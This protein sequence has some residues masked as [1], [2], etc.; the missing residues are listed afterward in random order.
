MSAISFVTSTLLPNE[1]H[2]SMVNYATTLK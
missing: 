2:H 1:S